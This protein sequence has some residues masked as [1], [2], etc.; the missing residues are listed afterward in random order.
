M[1]VENRTAHLTS[2]ETVLLVQ[3]D[4]GTLFR[5]HFEADVSESVS[6]R[7]ADTVPH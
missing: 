6:L 1:H 5:R 3:C 2:T 4:G 7:M